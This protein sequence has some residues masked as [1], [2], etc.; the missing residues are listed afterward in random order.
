[1]RK[2]MILLAGTLVAG[3]V[4]AQDTT[5][6][7]VGVQL[8]T[9]YVV[10]T[11]PV[12]AVRPVTTSTDLNV[13]AQQ[14]GS[15]IERDLDYNDTFRMVATPQALASGPVDYRQWTSLGVFFVIE[16]EL[17]SN[18]NGSQ[19]RVTA[20]DVPYTRT[21]QTQTFDLPAASAPNFRMAV[22]AVSDEIVR[23]LTDKPGAAASRIV[24]AR[25][26]RGRGSE[27]LMVDYDGENVQ[28]V[29]ASQDWI[30]SPALSPDGRK[31]AYGLRL[32]SGKIELR[33]RDL[34]THA[35]RVISNRA[36]I[37]YS[38]AYSPDGKRL[39]FTMAIGDGTE[40][41]EYDLTRGGA[42]RRLTNTR[43]T[44]QAPSYSPDGN[45]IAF[46]SNRLGNNHVFVAD[47]QG[48]NPTAL[49]PIG[50][51]RVKFTSADWSPT[52]N[53]IVLSGESKGGYHLMIVDPRRPQNAQQITETGINED[54]TWAPDG[55]HIAYTGVGREGPGM[56]VIDRGSGRT[57]RVLAGDFLK[58]AEWSGRLATASG[59]GN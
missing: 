51:G 2:L 4:S 34:T 45:R 38:P 41:H 46:D 25:N 10:G 43:Y 36:I 58:M 35:E 6:V 57:R 21:K 30:Y 54:P 53:D 5:R 17:T 22:H 3:A 8:S 56:Y 37:A 14:I 1:M 40:I 42:T 52:G 18:G 15:I 11:R 12:V 48:G 59:A 29:F 19:L 33:E 23:W 47:V 49:T 55:R 50:V 31:V 27:L 13:V 32:P 39:A 20:H 26:T 24:V 44:D 7:P 9:T 16:S 28:R